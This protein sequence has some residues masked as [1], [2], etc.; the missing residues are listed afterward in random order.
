MAENFLGS[1]KKIQRAA[2][3]MQDLNAW[4]TVSDFYTLS[5]NKDADR[6]VWLT[7]FYDLTALPTEDA[8]V[9]IG[10]A[11]HNL[12]SAL[13]ILWNDTIVECGGRPTK[14]SRFPI[15]DTADELKAPLSN[16]LEQQQIETEVQ[17]LLLHTVKPY[18]AGNYS[19]WALDDLNVRDKHQL[20]IPTLKIMNI[21]DVSFEDENGKEWPLNNIL[22]AD[23]PWT[24]RLKEFWGKN[25][26][27]KNKGQS[28]SNIFFDIGF[29]FEGKPIIPALDGIAKEV[30]RTVE[31]FESFLFGEG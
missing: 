1:K 2:K 16:L 17:N 26:K 6:N 15:R 7:L 25:L 29:P 11:L 8:A 5:I 31:A 30:L 4:I 13:D 14:W 21:W 22:I 3:H 20:L 24:I 12:R 9:M 23:E 10:D 18:K 19:I 28:A 27:V